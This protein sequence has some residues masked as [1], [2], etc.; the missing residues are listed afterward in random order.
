MRATFGNRHNPKKA[1][2]PDG[3][4]GAN[5]LTGGHQWGALGYK[6]LAV[7]AALYSVAIHESRSHVEGPLQ[8]D[9]RRCVFQQPQ[10]SQ[11][12][13]QGLDGTGTLPS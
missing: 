13:F 12:S 2:T 9:E 1:R 6:R 10:E 7:A 8:Q 11:T 5:G 4:W 3:H